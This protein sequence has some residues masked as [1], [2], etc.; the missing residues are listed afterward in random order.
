[1][2][3]GVMVSIVD[4]M[5]VLRNM[6]YNM[7]I[8]VWTRQVFYWDF[9]C[10][11]LY[12]ESLRKYI[13]ENHYITEKSGNPYVPREGKPI[14]APAHKRAKLEVETYVLHLA[15]QSLPRQLTENPYG[16]FD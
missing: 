9:H 3:R 4:P 7:Y 11:F 16:K 6:Y 10:S 14:R 13:V 5:Y 2:Q 1:M 12:R 8:L 15:T